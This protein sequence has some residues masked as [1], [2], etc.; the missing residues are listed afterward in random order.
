MVSECKLTLKISDLTSTASRFILD[1]Q[2]KWGYQW[3]SDTVELPRLKI[4]A[5]KTIEAILGDLDAPLKSKYMC[6]WAY[7]SIRD[8]H[9]TTALDLRLFHQRFNSL[10]G[11]REGRCLSRG[12]S[13]SGR[14]PLACQRFVGAIIKDLD[15]SAHNPPC[16][17]NCKTL[18][19]DEDSYRRVTGARAVS[20]K[21]TN[22][23]HLRYRQASKKTMAVSH[24]WSH[25]QGGR[26]EEVLT[27]GK[28]GGFNSCLHERYCK[29]AQ[30]VGCDSYWMDTPC[31]PEDH[32]LRKE[33]IANI[34]KV[35]SE[36]CITLV[37]DRDI[38]SIDVSAL[39]PLLEKGQ[40]IS[41][42]MLQLCECIISTLLVCDW[43]IRS[44]TLLESMRG[45]QHIYLLCKDDNLL[46]LKEIIDLV[47]NHGRIDIAV[48]FLANQHML[49]SVKHDEPYAYPFGHVE[50]QANL[51]FISKESAAVM[52]SRRH[53]SR[54]GDDIVIWSLLV[55]DEPYYD[56]AEW[57][58]DI[59]TSFN[60]VTPMG[61]LIS[62]VP[63]ISGVDGFSWA[64][65]KPGIHLSP[66]E[67]SK[68]VYHPF[69]QRDSR[70]AFVM[71]D[72]I[73]GRWG[74]HKFATNAPST[75]TNTEFERLRLNLA[76]SG[77]KR[78]VLLQPLKRNGGDL[79][80]KYLGCDGFLFGVCGSRDDNDVE[81]WRWAGVFEWALVE[82]LP[83]FMIEEGFWI[84]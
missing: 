75:N 17:G 8:T 25:G 83:E 61:F 71:K 4:V 18:H 7:K 40:S 41:P 58:K 6:S 59:A 51:G 13:C 35:F 45:R 76:E 78:G 67:V 15:Q 68:K 69:S 54:D 29:L 39:L 74:V 42:A 53:A 66:S 3:Q 37:C 20:I 49:P 52:L 81:R 23:N 73:Q 34:N 36:S 9:L 30:N 62:S 56:A 21:D 47:C 70:R 24:V 79:A 12:E 50:E 44:W 16:A 22:R 31:I 63:R 32:Q 38:M 55:A 60:L 43:N 11:T 46:S 26:P 19:W 65:K 2:L 1:R 14:S 80:N 33:S 64:P 77:Y 27:N 57:W 5:N 10:F 72:G 28:P 84:R 48:L 82:S